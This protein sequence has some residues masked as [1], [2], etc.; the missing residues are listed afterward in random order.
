MALSSAFNKFYKSF[1]NREI[2]KQLCGYLQYA[3]SSSL[4]KNEDFGA[5]ALKPVS[6]DLS[7]ITPYFPNT[8]NLAAYV[9]QSDT[10]KNLVNLN[11]NLSKIEK[12]PFIVDKILKLDFEKDMKSHIIFL[13]DFV[14]MEEIGNFIT[15]NPM[16]LC[17]PLE[18]LQVRVNYLYSKGFKGDQINRIISKN[19]FWLMFS[20]IRI[21]DRL[22]FYQKCLTLCGRE[23][24]DLAVKQ[25]KLIT[26]NLHA[27]KCNLFVIKEEMGFED[28]EVK[29]IVLNKPKLLMLNQRNLLERFN[30]IHNEMKISHQTILKTPEILMCRKFRI[31]QR[32]LFLEKLGRSQYNPKKENYVPIKSLIEDTDTEF[33]RNIAKCSVDDFNTF[34]KTL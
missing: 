7:T 5:N 10:L 28:N 11:V 4:I 20:T 23:V 17:E 29:E 16:I 3:T 24:R 2:T 15:K 22:G 26:Y 14:G 9:N 6:E 25:P 32:H 12:K 18:D 13:N 34:L 1:R 27:V 30:F 19:P 8:F 21:D 31:K 33:C